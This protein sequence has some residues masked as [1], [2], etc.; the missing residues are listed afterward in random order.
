MSSRVIVVYATEEPPARWDASLFLAGPTPRAPNI[1]TWRQDAVAEIERRWNCPGVLVVFLPEPRDGEWS[2]HD[3]QRTWE[4][5]WGDRCD[6][7]LFWIPR[8]PGM[9]SLTTDDEWI[10][11]KDSGRAVL[12]TPPSTESIRLLARNHNVA[13]CD[14]LADTVVA[15]LG[16]LGSGAN[17]AGGQRHIPLL[18]WR[19][20]S[21]QNWLSAL[22][23]AGNELRAAR[24][25]WTFRGGDHHDHT[26]RVIFWALHAQVY[27]V[28]EDRVKDNGV[29]LAQPE[30]ATVLAYRPAPTLTDTEIVLVSE[31]RSPSEAEDGLVR[32]LPG[33]SD[34]SPTDPATLAAAEFS[35]ETGLCI[36]PDR[37]VRH[38][39][40]QLAATVT[41]HRL[42]LF[43]VVLTAEEIDQI[44][45]TDAVLGHAGQAEITYPQVIRLHELLAADDADWT[46]LGALTEVLLGP[47]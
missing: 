9:R 2:Y 17:R 41:A 11:W 31:F 33:G 22:E 1:R 28:A 7:V 24:L 25:E 36:K 35:E 39:S 34:L 44:R 45:R 13:S 42:F 29:M 37:L 23:Q 4:L 19:L 5:Y 27:V 46:T 10:R 32:E 21:F 3:T 30:I 18:V 47:P 20:P 16:L 14:T 38:R 26:D 8:G 6:L 43:S 15:A 12:G 40:R